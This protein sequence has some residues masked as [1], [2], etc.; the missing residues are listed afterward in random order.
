MLVLLDC[1]LLPVDDLLLLSLHGNLLRAQG[2]AVE[3]CCG[4]H[5]EAYGHEV[6]HHLRIHNWHLLREHIGKKRVVDWNILMSFN[7]RLGDLLD[8]LLCDW[9]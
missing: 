2:L 4:G 6:L 7:L 8:G 1:L 9:L 3:T 5:R